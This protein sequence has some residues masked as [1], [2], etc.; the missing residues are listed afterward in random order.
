MQIRQLPE[1]S[2]SRRRQEK[3]RS[4]KGERG[5]QGEKRDGGRESA[6][7]QSLT[8]AID[9]FPLLPSELYF[10]LLCTNEVRRKK[11]TGTTPSL[12]LFSTLSLHLALTLFPLSLCL[13][14]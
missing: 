4:R 3:K 11:A 8:R 10:L 2:F 5:G 14:L 6:V 12:S 7:V 13:L 9:L 1:S